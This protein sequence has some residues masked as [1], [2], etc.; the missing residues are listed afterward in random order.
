MYGF[1]IAKLHILLITPYTSNSD[2]L[3]TIA[4]FNALYGF[5]YL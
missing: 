3:T 4:F 1:T 2:Y 5:M